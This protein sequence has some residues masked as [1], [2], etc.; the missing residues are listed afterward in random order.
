MNE[1]QPQEPNVAWDREETDACEKGTPGC[2]IRH[3]SDKPETD[4]ETW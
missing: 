4:C 1:T 3:A 2:C